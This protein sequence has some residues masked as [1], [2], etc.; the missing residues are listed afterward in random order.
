MS[1]L[2]DAAAQVPAW[3]QPLGDDAAPCG[4]D[5]E[6]DNEFLE[7]S[8][9]AL[10]KPESQFGPAEPPD[11][12]AVRAAAASLLE[13]SRDLRLAIY[14]LRA[15]VRMQGW[16]ALP[17]GLQL[18]TGLVEQLWDHV[19]PMPDPDDG[20]MYARVNALALLRE[21]EGLIGDLRTTHVF[22]DR[23]VGEITGR[24]IELAALLVPAVADEAVPSKDS[25][26]QMFSA[27]LERTP[28]LRALGPEILLKAKALQ[29]A[30]HEKLGS[31]DAP[32]LKPLLVLV[33]AMIALLP[34]EAEA[35]TD[36]GAA[37]GGQGGAGDGAPRG[38]GRGLSGA[39]TSRDE[40]LRAIDMVCQYLEKAE[41]SN[42]APLFLRRARQLVNHNF[43]QLMKELAPDALSDVARI[44]G[45]NPD[46]V[47][48]PERG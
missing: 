39:V 6:Y 20:D 48:T 26:T 8:Q 22:R 42:P 23:A 1:D 32:D 28:E 36:D 19:H 11:W 35:V 14:W 43:L 10:G 47:E 17:V 27:A 16:R 29:S 3:L 38:G 12:P 44:V 13:R 24:S 9:A 21:P 15:G 4:P 2:D 34:P 40:A 5:L 37:E 25:L 46:T 30:T 33:N 18:V 7:L 45:V 31:S 41:P